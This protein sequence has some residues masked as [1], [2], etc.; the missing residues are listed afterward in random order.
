MLP[1]Y[2]IGGNALASTDSSFAETEINV[3]GDGSVS[4]GIL[5]NKTKGKNLTK[6]L[7]VTKAQPQKVH[8]RQAMR[9]T[10]LLQ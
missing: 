8:I 10:T 3:V 5:A 2:S 9:L 1:Y 6:R 7:V 4:V